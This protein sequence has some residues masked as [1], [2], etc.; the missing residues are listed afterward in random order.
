MARLQPS[1][2]WRAGADMWDSEELKKP[3][4][5]GGGVDASLSG[6]PRQNRRQATVQTR[7]G[8]SGSGVSDAEREML[9]AS[10]RAAAPPQPPLT[11]WRCVGTWN[12]KTNPTRPPR[13]TDESFYLPK[14]VS[15]KQNSPSVVWHTLKRLPPATARAVLLKNAA[16]DKR[17]GKVRRELP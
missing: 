16:A 17:G 3:W 1:S 5:W 4:P 12:M 8:S 7:D 10:S 13:I 2:S 11:L 6:R 9:Q 15:K 14:C